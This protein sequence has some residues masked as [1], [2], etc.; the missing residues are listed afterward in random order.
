MTTE[1]QEAERLELK[2]LYEGKEFKVIFQNG[3]TATV[4]DLAKEVHAHTGLDPLRQRIEY[5]GIVF[6]PPDTDKW[7]PLLDDLNFRSGDHFDVSKSARPL[8]EGEAAL[9]IKESEM[10]LQTLTSELEILGQKK[11][12]VKVATVIANDG[13]LAVTIRELD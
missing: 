10:T 12:L 3:A 1:K 2:G 7:A 8:S 13:D 6:D 11:T 9:T 5:R 4:A